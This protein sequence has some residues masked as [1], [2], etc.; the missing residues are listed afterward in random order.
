MTTAV[1]QEVAAADADLIADYRVSSAQLDAVAR[2]LGYADGFAGLLQSE[3]R[4]PQCQVR[5]RW[6]LLKQFWQMEEARL[7][8]KASRLSGFSDPKV[9]AEAEQLNARIRQIHAFF[10]EPERVAATDNVLERRRE[11]TY[12][13]RKLQQLGDRI[14][15][16][17][18]RTTT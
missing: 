16:L 7:M 13:Q 5:M 14:L 10:A 3:D 1:D 12:L 6:N 8:H 4:C 11:Q 17:A 15:A 9:Q 18:G 2:E